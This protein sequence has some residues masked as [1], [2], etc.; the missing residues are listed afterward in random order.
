MDV[1]VTERVSRNT[2]KMMANQTVILVTV[3]RIVFPSS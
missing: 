2:K 1:A 3:A